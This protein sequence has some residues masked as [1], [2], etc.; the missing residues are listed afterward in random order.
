MVREIFD[1]RSRGMGALT[2]AINLQDRGVTN[3]GKSWTKSSILALLR[4]DAVAGRVVFGRRDRATRCKKP[5]DQWIIVQAHDPL[6]PLDLWDTV[7]SMM[8]GATAGDNKGSPKSTYLFTGILRCNDGSSMQIESGKSGTGKRYWYYNCR[9]AQKKG[10]GNNRRISARSFDEWMVGVILDRVFTRSF[11]S[12][13]VRDLNEACGTWVKDHRKRRQAISSALSAVEERNSKIYELF[14]TYGR[15][16]PNL[17]DLTKRLRENNK[18]I[19]ELE[20]K[21]AGIDAEEQPKLTVSQEDI[22]E[23]ERALRYIINTTESPKKLRHFFGTFIDRIILGDDSVRI[24]YRPE[25]LIKNQEPIK[26]PSKAIWL[27][28]TGSNCRPSD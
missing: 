16:T 24:E 21:L 17:G 19:G 9:L 14:E 15:D 13:V 6:V 27:P 1:M 7:Q 18:R 11:L 2:I 5:R 20:R 8:D 4:N 3:R 28:G 22:A 26:V 25:S 10:S 23:L 12:D